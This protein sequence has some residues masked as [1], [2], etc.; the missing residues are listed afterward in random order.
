MDK[1]RL[2]KLRSE[3]TNIKPIINVGKGGI[4]D[5]LIMELK[6]HIKERHLVKVKVLKSASYEDGIDAI[7]ENLA[8]ATRT[9]VIDVRGSSV[10]LYR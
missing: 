9:T 3:A 8:E 7:A 6:K 1:E 5:Q 2:Y 4:T 10:V